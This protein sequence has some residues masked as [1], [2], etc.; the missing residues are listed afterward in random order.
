MSPTSE[1]DRGRSHPGGA[2]E[3][4]PAPTRGSRRPRRN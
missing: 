1:T 3:P 2:F 4:E